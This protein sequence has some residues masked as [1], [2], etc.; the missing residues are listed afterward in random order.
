MKSGARINSYLSMKLPIAASTSAAA[1]QQPAALQQTNAVLIVPLD[2]VIFARATALALR[3]VEL[4]L[5]DIRN[6][7]MAA[8]QHELAQIVSAQAAQKHFAAFAMS[9]HALNIRIIAVLPVGKRANLKHSVAMVRWSPVNNAMAPM[10]SCGME[11]L[12]IQDV[13]NNRHGAMVLSIIQETP[14]EIA[15]VQTALLIGQVMNAAERNVAQRVMQPEDA[16]LASHV[17]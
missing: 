6:A 17:I 11:A 15:I 14:M 13:H 2:R 1:H 3:A 16:L 12:G 4:V 9:M 5:R 8:L 10:L 7:A